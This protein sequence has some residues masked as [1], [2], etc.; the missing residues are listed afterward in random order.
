[1]LGTARLIAWATL[2]AVLSTLSFAGNATADPP[3]DA[4]YRWETALGVAVQSAVLVLAIVLIAGRIGARDTFGL[5]RPRSWP[6]A[7][8]LALLLVVA[9]NV[10]VVALS[11]LL[12][13]GEEQGLVPEDW[14]ADRAPQF[15]VNGAV[16]AGVVPVVEELTFR[17]VG[18]ALL[19]R[20]GV[21]AAI[22]LVGVAFALVHG[23]L[24][25][26]VIFAAFGSGLAYLRHRTG[27][28]YPCIAVHGVFN[29]L[30]LAVSVAS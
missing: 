7:L 11:P 17:G 8:V 29:A 25:G 1:M 19:R 3:P 14:D 20:F 22:V 23:L 13:P 26:L 15:F 12:Q 16:I 10:L 2:V 9:I 27:S 6:Q 21:A 5:R 30:A 4:V 24:E 28:I 18:F